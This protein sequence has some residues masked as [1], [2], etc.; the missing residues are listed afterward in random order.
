MMAWFPD[1]A[2]C[3]VWGG[4]RFRFP[5]TEATFVEDSR[6]HELP[7]YV[8]VA[9]TGELLA[10][11]QYYLRVGRCHLGRLVVAPTHRGRGV[12]ERLV[13]ELVTLGSNRL[14][15][16]ESSLFVVP[17]NTRAVALYRRLGFT[18]TA[19][20]EPDAENVAY[21]YM[22]AAVQ[23]VG[24]PASR[25][26]SVPSSQPVGVPAGQQVSESVDPADEPT[27]RSG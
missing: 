20:P 18:P 17:D 2:S 19:Y 21:L 1:A 25:Q 11:G 13:R 22:T 8:L 6:V 4:H 3:H 16:S 10:Y 24:V 15:V 26:V 23:R 9:D 14:G 12:G 27:S 5:F 7:T